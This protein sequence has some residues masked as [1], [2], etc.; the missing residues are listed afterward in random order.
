M[1]NGVSHRCYQ[2]TGLDRDAHA[3]DVESTRTGSREICIHII[4]YVVSLP[5]L[6]QM[7]QQPPPPPPLPQISRL[8]FLDINCSL[9]RKATGSRNRAATF[10]E[11][12]NWASRHASSI[13]ARAHSM[14]I[15]ID[16][17]LSVFLPPSVAK[18][19]SGNPSFRGLVRKRCQS[20]E[21]DREGCSRP[22][23]FSSSAAQ[24][25]ASSLA[26]EPCW[27]GGF[28]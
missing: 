17:F 1:C 21:L 24:H 19:L 27:W 12:V 14:Y 3:R 11:P 23:D 26:Q 16:G 9:S 25:A 6:L 5:A 2:A 7:L 4:I 10:H 20:L 18:S 13:C 8:T 15:A 22:S 28:D